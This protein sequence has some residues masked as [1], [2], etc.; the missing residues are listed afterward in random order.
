MKKILGK[1][2]ILR[3]ARCTDVEN[4]L[5]VK[6]RKRLRTKDNEESLVRKDWR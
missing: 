2:E 6:E 4:H 1:L 5:N 3:K